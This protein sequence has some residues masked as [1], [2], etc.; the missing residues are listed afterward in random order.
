MPELPEVEVLRCSLSRR[1]LDRLIERIEVRTP[2]LREPVD[3]A[4][5]ERWV[6][7]R[8]VR[9]LRRRAKYLLI[10]LDGDATLIVHLG[11][12]G[13]LTVVA[14]DEPLAPHEHL[15]FHLDRGERLR[16]VDPRRFG[17]IFA[18]PTAQLEEDPH[19]AHLGVEPLDAALD[20]AYLARCARGRRGPVKNFV[21]DG[22]VVVGVGNIYASEALW[23]ARIHPRRSVARIALRRWQRLAAAIKEVLAA[24]IEEGGTTLNDFADGEGNA[25]YFQVSLAVYGREGEP[26]PRCR[27]PIRRLALSGR[28]T[29]Y[30]SA[31]QR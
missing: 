7:G 2:A 19:L 18:R 13:R 9:A 17:L 10:D 25:G 24:A 30:C 4:E 15:A 1:L 23:R 31:C 11:M 26:C 8:R 14:E 20:G 5:L 6:A 12:S 21:M 29:F 16:F 28:S 22:R 3:A 27:R